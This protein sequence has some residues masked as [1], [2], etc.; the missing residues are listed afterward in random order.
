MTDKAD[1]GKV[2]RLKDARIITTDSLP[3][4]YREAL[5]Q[6]LDDDQVTALINLHDRLVKDAGK[7]GAKPLNQ[8]FVPL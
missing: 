1:E 4:A 2:K 5:E 7:A 3:D 6:E 8:C